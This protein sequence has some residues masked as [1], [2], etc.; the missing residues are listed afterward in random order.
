MINLKELRKSHNFTQKRL[1]N[2]LCLGLRQYQRCEEANY[3]SKQASKILALIIRL[4]KEHGD[5]YLNIDC[6]QIELT[7]KDVNSIIECTP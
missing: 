2:M 3:L 1:A 6:M 4:N 5:N 7:V